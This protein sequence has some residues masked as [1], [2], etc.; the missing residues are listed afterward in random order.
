MGK[1]ILTAAILIGV[2][3]AVG[4]VLNSVLRVYN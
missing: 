3:F 4:Y 2:L 1:M